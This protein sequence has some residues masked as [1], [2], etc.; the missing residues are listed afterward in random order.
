LELDVSSCNNLESILIVNE[1][2]DI[3][4]G[5]EKEKKKREG[6]RNTQ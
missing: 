2:R 5:R 1:M 6:K 4:E 3:G